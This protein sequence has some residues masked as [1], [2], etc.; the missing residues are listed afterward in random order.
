MFQFLNIIRPK[1]CSLQHIHL[2]YFFLSYSTTRRHYSYLILGLSTAGSLLSFSA[3]PSQQA[4][5]AL[6]VDFQFLAEQLR[7]SFPLWYNLCLLSWLYNQQPVFF[8]LP[9]RL[10]QDFSMQPPA[11][12]L[13]A[14]D[15]HDQAW[16]F[17]HIYRG[18][19]LDRNRWFLIRRKK[20]FKLCNFMP[21]HKYVECYIIEYEYKSCFYHLYTYNIRVLVD[22][23]QLLHD[24]S[25]YSLVFGSLPFC[26]HYI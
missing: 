10:F 19:L 14:R 8:S 3:K 6:M 4:T 5:Q 20:L 18:I 16:T 17:R 1:I 24:D 22:C 26:P 9:K 15:L 25:F 7:K 2:D 23:A 13:T 21:L 12:E 11:Q